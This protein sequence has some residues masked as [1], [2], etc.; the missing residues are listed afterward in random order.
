M[1]DILVAT[2]LAAHVKVGEIEF[3]LQTQILSG[4]HNRQEIIG[5]VKRSRVLHFLMHNRDRFVTVWQIYDYV[6]FGEV[7]PD[8]SVIKVYIHQIRRE[9]RLV[10]NGN[11]HI[12]SVWRK[13]YSLQETPPF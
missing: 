6:Y 1:T 8:A 10:A 12:K 11:V 3:D 7:G 9:L 2:D 5:G 4:P 13:G